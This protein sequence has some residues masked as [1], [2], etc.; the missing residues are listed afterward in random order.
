MEVFSGNTADPKTLSAQIEKI[1]R[2][3][4]TL[5]KDL[6]AITRNRLRPLDSGLGAHEFSMETKMTASQRHAF[7]LLK[8][9]PSA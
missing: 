8:L 7:E 3:F 9:N 2:R 6:G 5:L 4:A 1:R